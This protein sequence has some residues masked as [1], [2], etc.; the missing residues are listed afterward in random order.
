M[1]DT[2]MASLQF[3]SQNVKA[4]KLA[5]LTPGIALTPTQSRNIAVKRRSLSF[6]PVD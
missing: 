6:I 3:P 4:E 5:D 1:P 2:S